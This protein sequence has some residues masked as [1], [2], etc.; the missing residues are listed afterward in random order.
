MKLNLIAVAALCVAWPA[1]AVQAPVASVSSGSLEERLNQL[2]RVI[3]ARN[4]AQ[5][6]LLNQ[7]NMLQEEVAELRGVTEEHA[8]QLEQLLT[9]QRELYQEID[10]RLANQSSAPANTQVIDSSAVTGGSNNTADYSGNLSENDAYDRAIK[11]VLEDKRY[12]DAIPAF[13]QFIERFPNSSYAPNAHYW[14][15]QLLFSDGNY[16]G[17]AEQFKTVVDDYPDS[18]KRADC[19]LKLGS[20]ARQQGQNAAARDYFNQ[21]IKGYADSTEAGLARQRL[22]EL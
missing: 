3:D 22:S 1:L 18:N 11:L 10:R 5:M 2:E 16:D 8:F 19:L 14:L 17:A 7:V 13:Q 21:V 6:N 9:R 4:S 12:Q 15:G 20:I